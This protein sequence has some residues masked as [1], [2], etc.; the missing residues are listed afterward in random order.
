LS[1]YMFKMKN[2]GDIPRICKDMDLLYREGKIKT[3]GVSHFLI[4][5]L[6]D[7]YKIH[8]AA[9]VGVTVSTAGQLITA[10]SL[11]NAIGTPIVSW[12]RQR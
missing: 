7:L 3:I 11:A 9:S 12:Q 10:F 6:K 4:R 1:D 2:P 5:H 8:V